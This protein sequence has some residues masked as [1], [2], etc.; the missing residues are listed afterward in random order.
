MAAG[1]EFEAM[2]FVEP[3]FGPGERFP[4][5]L[6]TQL[7]LFASEQEAIDSAR[8]AW[9]DHRASGSRDVAWWIVRVPG[10]S[11]ARWIADGASPVERVLDLRSNKL[12]E[13][14]ADVG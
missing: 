13:V 1:T 10:E 11:L 8:Q 4:G 3:A 14:D 7:G 12:I 9:S 5:T 2:Q 6:E